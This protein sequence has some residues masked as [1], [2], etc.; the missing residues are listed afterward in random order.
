MSEMRNGVYFPR[1][2]SPMTLF[3]SAKK[4][5]VASSCIS[6]S[7][8]QPVENYSFNN[9]LL[10]LSRGWC[11]DCRAAAAPSCWDD[12]EVLSPRAAEKRLKEQVPTAALQEAAALLA[13][14]QCRGE[15]ALHALT[16]LSAPSWDITLRAGGR[17]L[18]G[19]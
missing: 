10:R 16:L 7:N 15:E 6:S 2:P 3:S 5:T 13:D 19:T 1:S 12:H 4:V 14:V 9:E 18:N 8:K 11:S 17:Q